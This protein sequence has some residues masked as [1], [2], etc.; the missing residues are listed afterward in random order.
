MRYDF[1]SYRTQDLARKLSI[2]R[3]R[4]L[5]VMVTGA[6]GAG[7]STTLNALFQRQIAKV[8]AGVDPET[9]ELDAYKLND[10][11]R[12]WDTPGLGDGVARDRAHQQ[13]LIA[14]LNKTYCLD[15]QHYGFI[16][17]ALVIVEGANRDLGTTIH[18]LR[19][20][21]V[22][23]IQRER[24]LVVINQADV[25]MKGRHWCH[26]LNRPDARLEEFLQAQ[27]LSIQSRVRE[28]TGV[29]IRRPICYSAEY[30]FGVREVFDFIVDQMPLKRRPCPCA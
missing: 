9:K 24:I 30:G 21:I 23:H 29:S 18:L 17:L 11:C 10:L 22:P 7:K 1:S 14:L 12:F 26:D 5:D 15:N 27:A 16:D 3:F 28:A 2:A 13:K 19:D 20:I 4:P 25:A 6:T 8:G